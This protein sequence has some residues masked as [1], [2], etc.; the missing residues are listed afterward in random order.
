MSRH[1]AL[2]F[3][4]ALL[5][6]AVSA[7]DAALDISGV[8]EVLERNIR[9]FV[10]LDDEPCDAE[11][12]LVRRRFRALEKETRE[13]LEPFGYY[14]PTINTLLST[15]GKCWQATLTI[16]PGEPVR[17]RSV[18]IAVTGDAATDTA[19]EKLPR[20]DALQPGKV[21]QH[22]DYDG[23]K[24][25]LQTLA[26]DRGY[27]EADFTES[28]LEVWPDDG[29]ADVTLH[30]ASGP[31]YRFGEIR[32]DQDFL[33][34]E[35]ARGFVDLHP[36]TWYDSAELAQA[37]RDLSESA[38]FGVVDIS[39]ELAQARDGKVPIRIALQPGIRV[40]YTVG[41]GVSTDTGARVRAGY[42]NNRLNARGHRIVS[43]LSVSS[44]IQGLTAEYRIP[45]EDP[46]RE[47]FS[48]AGAISNEETDTFDS[49][50]QR[51]GLRWTKA[52]SVKWLRTLSL[53]VNNESFDIGGNVDSS[54]FVVPGIAFDQKIADRDIFPSRGRR[55]GVE[56]RGTDETL[57][58]TTS[59]FQT[60]MWARWIRSFGTGNR[61]LLR[62]NA[63]VTASGDFSQLPPSVR[64]F[65]G[66]DESVRGYDYDSLG[67]RDEDGNVI[68]GTNLLVASVE[69]ERHLFGNFYGAA[70]VDAGN[71]FDNTDFEPETGVGLGIKWRSP[72]GPVRVYLGYPVTADDPKVRFHLRLGADL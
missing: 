48:I 52:M 9:A 47:W 51:I 60:T 57:G 2:V 20:R 26:A 33:D 30:F 41:V 40:E 32:I 23:L 53:D 24:R 42:R 17:Y 12:W 38:Y 11:D 16:D 39:P 14:R 10:S 5:T 43:D 55:L 22:A 15:G 46:R 36:G 69:Y 31:R 45:R 27:L 64:F 56:L 8:D 59:Y 29:A 50:A 3:A 35:I 71:A 61:V 18:D 68:G 65:A 6:G 63:G 21:L 58:S 28:Q 37:Y 70:F 7:A 66:G 34:P 44:V 4:L 1:H 54:R 67:P 25:Q 13:S 72:L 62:M 19:F 49:E